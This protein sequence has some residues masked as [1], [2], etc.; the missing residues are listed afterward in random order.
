VHS[1]D[2]NPT[3]AATHII[4]TASPTAAEAFATGS[5]RPPRGNIRISRGHRVS[6][7]VHKPREVPAREVPAREV[8]APDAAPPSDGMRFDETG[9]VSLDHIYT[10]PDPRAYFTTLRRLDYVIPQLARPFFAQFIE[11]RRAR[12]QRSATVLDVGCSYGINAALLRCGL[13][14]D[15]LYDR[16]GEQGGEAPDRATL[17]A[18]DRD[19]VQARTTRATPRFIGLDSSRPAVAYARA[20][21]FL[22]DAICADLETNDPTEAERAVLA[23]A[24]LVVST[25]CIGYVTERTIGRIARAAERSERP[26]MAHFVLRMFPFDPVTDVLDTLGYETSHVEGVFPQRRF[27]SP[28][29]QQQVLDTLAS[30]GV[31]PRGLESDGWLYAA[32]HV[33]RPRRPA[34]RPA[35]RTTHPADSLTGPRR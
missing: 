4:T 6:N 25:G 35:A 32:L 18:R 14:M 22:D 12:L 7:G 9:K 24:D 20:A 10:Q 33:S 11:E 3:D 27:A 17:L 31:D 2:A 19:L 29:E 23:S 26:W 34:P 8:P 30:V 13:T 16:Y 1:N 21:G 15:D 28:Q 5:A